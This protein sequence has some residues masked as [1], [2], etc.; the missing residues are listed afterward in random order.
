MQTK[1][2]NQF[3][4][5]SNTTFK[6]VVKINSEIRALKK[7]MEKEPKEI[8][9]KEEMAFYCSVS[10]KTIDR[11]RNNGLKFMQKGRNGK[12]FFKVKDVESFLNKR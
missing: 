9:T 3:K 7:E 8:Y 6:Q 12:V 1:D 4:K 2:F 5:I 11:W 10:K